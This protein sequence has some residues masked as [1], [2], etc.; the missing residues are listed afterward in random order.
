MKSPTLHYLHGI[1]PALVKLTSLQWIYCG[2][3]ISIYSAL[4][5]PSCFHNYLS[6]SLVTS[7]IKLC[8]TKKMKRENSK[9]KGARS[10]FFSA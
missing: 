6:F 3:K 2:K 8:L 4:T 7:E 5:S 10:R 1:T 9:N